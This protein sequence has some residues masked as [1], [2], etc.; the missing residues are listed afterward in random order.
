MRSRC[1]AI[2]LAAVLNLTF[3]IEP[4]TG[5]AEIRVLRGWLADEEC[6][7]GRGDEAKPR[8]GPTNPRVC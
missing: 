5:A 1:G 6:A 7:R 2:V 4:E 3:R 8:Y